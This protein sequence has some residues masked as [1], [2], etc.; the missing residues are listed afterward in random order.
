MLHFEI[1]LSCVLGNLNCCWSRKGRDRHSRPLGSSWRLASTAATAPESV[2]G[3]LVSKPS[4][5]QT[6]SWTPAT[7]QDAISYRALSA[8]KYEWGPESAWNSTGGLRKSLGTRTISRCTK[9]LTRAG[10]LQ[11]RQW[12]LQVSVKTAA[13][14]ER[15]SVR[16]WDCCILFRK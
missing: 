8:S 11:H 6:F 5:I 14:V 1:G 15:G 3:Q 7:A 4:W 13:A 2:Q 16:E 10:T 9:G 12:I